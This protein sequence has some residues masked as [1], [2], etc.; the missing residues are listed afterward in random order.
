[1]EASVFSAIALAGAFGLAFIA[2]RGACLSVEHALN[3]TRGLPYS[4]LAAP[5]GQTFLSRNAT[6]GAAVAVFRRIALYYARNGFSSLASIASR[7]VSS[8]MGGMFVQAASLA[9]S[10]GLE[11]TAQSVASLCVGGATA[12]SLASLVLFRSPAAAACAPVLVVAV[13]RAAVSRGAESERTR[14][15]E[16]V[17]DAL[18]CMEACLHA[19][20]SLPQTFYE[21]STQIDQPARGLFARVSRDLD[22][23]Y[24]MNEALERF[25]SV[26]ELPELSFVA[27]ALDVQ[28]ACGGSAT[29]ILRSAEA[30]VA[31]DLE[32]R[33]SL[34]VQTAQ[35]KLSAQIVSIMPFALMFVISAV[36]PGFL[37]PFFSSALG[38]ALLFVALGMLGC[39]VLMVRRMLAVEV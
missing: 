19:G 39:G 33:R 21:V 38:V 3:A 26:A 35:A 27:M 9:V 5:H 15:R 14:L 18:R 37:A 11:T 32:L 24:S 29:P 31:S 2:G 1:M 23:G 17:P 25:R 36:D 22:L 13:F 4:Q 16:Q 8:R 28:Y 7:L 30:S 20:L 34:R 6:I 10:K 12:V